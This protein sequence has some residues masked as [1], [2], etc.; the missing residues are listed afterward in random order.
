M[1]VLASS[2]AFGLAEARGQAAEAQRNPPELADI[3]A[4]TQLRHLKLSYAG[5]LHN[6]ELAEYE[7]GQMRKSF[8]LVGTLY[9]DYQNVP[10][11]KLIN[12]LGEPALAE[13]D[14]TIKAKN[15]QAF[16]KAF[17]RLN[18]A[19]NACHQAAGRPFIKIRT[20]TA[21]PFSNQVFRPEP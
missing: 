5:S 14:K 15:A 17:E 1:A 21:S 2:L 16:F 7:V 20:P 3:M 11:A 13:L 6:W 9:P 8:A 19:C 4:G 10:V 12:E 18:G